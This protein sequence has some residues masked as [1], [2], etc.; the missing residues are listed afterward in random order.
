[1][2]KILMALL[3]IASL[4]FANNASSQRVSYYYYPDANVYYNPRTH[5]Y[6]YGDNDNWGYYSTLPSTYHIGKKYVTIYGTSDND[7]IWRDNAIH[8]DKYKNWDKKDVKREYRQEKKDAKHEIKHEKKE[9]KR[10][11]KRDQ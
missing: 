1:M 11:A 7:E 4:S 6:A 10:E 2:K 9:E 3:V 8:R 5:Q